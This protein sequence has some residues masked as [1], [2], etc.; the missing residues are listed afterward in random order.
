MTTRFW[1]SLLGGLSLAAPS[2]ASAA[3]EERP[4]VAPADMQAVAPA[5]AR[6]TDD[7][8]FG[9]NWENPRLGKRDRSLV[10]ISA[11]IAGGKSAQLAGHLG[12]ALD[13]GVK[14][15]EISGLVTHLAFYSGWPNAVSATTVVRE[16]FEQRKIGSSQVAPARMPPLPLDAEREKLRADGVAASVAPTAPGL[17]RFT[18]DVLFADLWRRP[19]LSPRDRSVVT[20]A[21]LTMAG[22]AGQLPFHI[23]R[24]LDNGVTQA[25]LGE[26]MT[27]LAFYAGWPKA[28][29]GVELVREAVATRAATAPAA[30]TIAPHGSGPL[31]DGPASHFI[32]KVRVS[33]PFNASAPSRL[34]GATV[35]FQPGARTAWHSHP[36]G[37]TLIVT[38]GV[39]WTQVEGGP[40]VEMRAGDV[41]VCPPGARHWHGASLGA[42]MSHV[43]IAEALDGK[44]VDWAE[45]V[46][47]ADY[48]KGLQAGATPG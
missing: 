47:D 40:V 37:Q 19:D 9:D 20:V 22:D 48:R 17:A 29:A 44:V 16:V 24:A 2:I 21:A 4:S 6:Y 34:G 31:S 33:A 45:Q 12:R 3:E 15:S 41:I 8:L 7:V 10:T 28:M 38:E 23:G 43:A 13:N 36:L 5:L 25:D 39:G 11:L 35:T 26:E 27:H 14:P 42:A 1:R 32:G 18:D 46:S 30:L